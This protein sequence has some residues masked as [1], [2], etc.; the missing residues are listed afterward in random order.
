MKRKMRRRMREED[1]EEVAA[2]LD[3]NDV[4]CEQVDTYACDH[5]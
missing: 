3:S 1:E 5:A 4:S 2:A